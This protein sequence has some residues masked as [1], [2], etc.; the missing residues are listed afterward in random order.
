MECNMT[1]CVMSR[2]G[3][4]KMR[5]ILFFVVVVA[6][7]FGPGGLKAV[8]RRTT[9]LK[10]FGNKP[11][12]EDSKFDLDYALNRR[13][14]DQIRADEARIVEE[15]RARAERIVEEIRARGKRRRADALVAVLLGLIGGGTII[16]LATEEAKYFKKK[17]AEIKKNPRK[18]KKIPR[19]LDITGRPDVCDAPPTIELPRS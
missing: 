4:N 16:G 12:A 15:I 18:S 11:G 6:N 7:A 19:R 8:P 10:D 17:I 3:C 5:F 13:A 14:I 1:S 9:S 2:L